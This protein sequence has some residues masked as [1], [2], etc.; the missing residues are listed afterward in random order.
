MR[1]PQLKR[2]VLYG[3][4]AK[5]FGKEHSFAVKNAAEAIRALRANFRGFEAYLCGAH[6]SGVGF[7]VFVGGNSLADAKEIHNPA[8]AA[9]VIRFVPVAIGAGS[10]PFKIILGVVLIAA[11]V[12]ASAYGQGWLAGALGSMGASLI[13]GGVA[14]LLSNPPKIKDPTRPGEGKDSF[15]FSGPENTAVQGRAVPLGYGRMIV[16]SAVISAGIET[17]EST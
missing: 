17:H 7:R 6:Q 15:I 14:Q 3:E 13:I 11:A 12:V 16:G 10:G 1:V 9:E 4:L 2:I 8:G 5:R